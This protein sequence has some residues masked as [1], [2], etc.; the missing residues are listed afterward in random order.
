MRYLAVW[1]SSA[2][3][4]GRV[5]TLTVDTGAQSQR[6][7]WS[8]GQPWPT[9]AERAGRHLYYGD[10]II[11]TLDKFLYRFFGFGEP[12]KSYI[13]PLRI[14]HMKNPVICFDE[15]HS[16]ESEAL[17]N[18]ERL[19]RTL[20]EKGKDVALMTATMPSEL[21]ALFNPYL[22][23][24]DFTAGEGERL[25]TAWRRA[26]LPYRSE[27]R[28][29]YIPAAVARPEDKP[30]SPAIERMIEEAEQRTAAGR[31][32]IVTAESVRD[33]AAIF[34]RLK[35][36]IGFVP[37]CLYHGRLTQAQ[38]QKVYGELKQRDETGQGY[39][40][41]STSAIEVGCD[42]DAHVL[43]TQLCDPDRL[44]QR[45]GRCNRREKM[46]DATIIVVGDYVPEWATALPTDARV[47]YVGVLRANDGGLFN[48]ADFIPHVQKRL[49]TDP[50]VAVMFDMLYEYVYEARLENKKL[51]DNGLVI[52]RSWE[53]SITLYQGE[54][55]GKLLEPVTVPISRCRVPQNQQPT[56]LLNGGI[57]K[58]TY[59]DKTHRFQPERLGRWE[60]AYRNDIIVCWP[61]YTYKDGST[62]QPE[63]GYVDLPFLFHGPIPLYGSGKVLMQHGTDPDKIKIWYIDPKQVTPRPFEGLAS[64]PAA[65][66]VGDK[67]VVAE[68]SEGDE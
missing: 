14:R 63:L 21:E 37:V 11:T 33:A 7:C 56:V 44:V 31:R 47:A 25:M 59:D 2:A 27:K 26:L 5:I 8:D 29:H 36:T 6:Y 17:T 20:V 43:I 45:A 50:R 48:A 64:S 1:S 58:Q 34:Q 40:L 10:V 19:V 67:E 66:D 55:N 35:G 38:R 54:E 9:G 65:P 24:L 46:D 41:V 22:E 30:I 52:T 32:L 13:Y 60:N 53:P 4:A 18:F 3:V 12:K 57:Y 15:A 39:V 51:Y 28:L 61:D 49:E 23:T 68:E 16:Y 42:L 62:Y